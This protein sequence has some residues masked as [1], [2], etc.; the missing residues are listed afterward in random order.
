MRCAVGLQWGQGEGERG[1]ISVVTRGETKGGRAGR[2]LL[3][4]ASARS[5]YA[6]CALGQLVRQFWRQERQGKG[7]E[8]ETYKRKKMNIFREKKKALKKNFEKEAKKCDVVS[9]GGVFRFCVL[10]R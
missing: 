2:P 7:R 10:F 8:G 6:R 5:S 4:N 3:R 1:K 9:E